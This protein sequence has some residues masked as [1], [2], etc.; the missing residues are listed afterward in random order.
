MQKVIVLGSCNTGKTRLV[1][2]T[3]DTTPTDGISCVRLQA[4]GKLYVVWDTSGQPI[5]QSLARSMMKQSDVA[6]VLYNTLDTYMHALNCVSEAR[7]NGLRVVSVNTG[8]T[9][10]RIRADLEFKINLKRPDD[11]LQNILKQLC[12]ED[13]SNPYI[14]YCC[15]CSIV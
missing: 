12:K 4:H 1:K 9:Q 2:N 11:Y 13:S 6:I 5:Y 10:M 15:Q 3:S 14:E 8:R 7:A